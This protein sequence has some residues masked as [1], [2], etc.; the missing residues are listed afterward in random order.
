[1]KVKQLLPKDIEHLESLERGEG[2]TVEEFEKVL[3]MIVA[4]A[5][6]KKG[7]DGMGEGQGWS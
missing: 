3:D 6:R 2:P 7:I 1:M 4:N 5:K